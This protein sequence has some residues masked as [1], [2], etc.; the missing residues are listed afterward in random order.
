MEGKKG[1]LTI[2]CVALACAL[3]VTQAVAWEKVASKDGVTIHTRSVKGQDFKEFKG[4][5][6]IRTSLRSLVALITD[7]PAGPDWIAT[8]LK[9]MVL[10]HVSPTEMYAYTLS[11]AP[12]P[13]ADRDAVVHNVITQDRKTGVVTIE[14]EGV[15]GFI[16]EKKGVVRVKLIKGFW[17]LTPLGNGVVRVDY[18]VLSNPGGGL[19]AWLVNATATSQPLNTLRA[20]KKVVLREKY[21][22][23]SLDF[24]KE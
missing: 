5:V 12:W 13:V 3:S 24:I 4:T 22:A 18:Q 11:D 19:P 10:K 9:G 23:A 6:E 17:Q 2:I 7:I 15:P 21:Q 8:C 1:L 20:M 16:P 14:F